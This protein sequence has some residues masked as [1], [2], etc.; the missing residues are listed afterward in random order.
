MVASFARY[1]GLYSASLVSCGCCCQWLS[2]NLP[3]PLCAYLT[4]RSW[5]PIILSLLLWV[6]S[7]LYLYFI[8]LTLHHHFLLYLY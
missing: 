4:Q 6:P 1:V 8:P 2:L 7:C 3:K 5:G